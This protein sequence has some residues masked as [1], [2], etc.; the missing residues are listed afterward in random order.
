MGKVPIH[1][2]LGDGSRLVSYE[3]KPTHGE[4]VGFADTTEVVWRTPIQRARYHV[5]NYKG[6]KFQL[7]GGIRTPYFINLRG[8][9][10]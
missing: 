7:L 1:V 6:R 3:N 2:R 8:E 4:V 5:V 9:K 10:L